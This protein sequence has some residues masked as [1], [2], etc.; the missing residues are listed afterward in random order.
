MDPVTSSAYGVKPD[1]RILDKILN[2]AERNYM[3]LQ[4]LQSVLSP[5][6]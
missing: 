2:V 1:S 3:S 5:L 4:L 6:L